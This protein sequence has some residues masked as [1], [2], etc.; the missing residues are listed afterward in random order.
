MLSA[1]LYFMRKKISG[2]PMFFNRRVA[3]VVKRKKGEH[4]EL[5]RKMGRSMQDVG[6][7]ILPIG[8]L[9]N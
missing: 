2:K 1:L 6:R 9:I 3:K 7:Y 4:I 5:K 8:C